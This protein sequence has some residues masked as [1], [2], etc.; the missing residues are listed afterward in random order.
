MT[1]SAASLLVLALLTPWSAPSW[2]GSGEGAV[3]DDL[4]VHHAEDPDAPVVTEANLLASERFWPYQVE[5]VRPWQVPGG[6]QAIQPGVP[7]VLIRVESGGLARVDFGRDGL[8]E[9]PVAETDLLDRANQ[10]RR[11]E[12]YK[13]APNLVLALGPRLLDSESAPP[14]P[15]GMNR[16][17]KPVGFLCVFAD[18]G[19]A[20]FADLVG[21]L[22][23][24]RGRHGVASVLLPQGEHA[25]SELGEQ[26]RTLGWT[27]P[28]VYDGLSELYTRSL[29]PEGSRPPA[30]LLATS[31]GRVLFQGTWRSDLVPEL[32][33]ALEKGFGGASDRAGVSPGTASERR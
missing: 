28:F 3:V 27:V 8:H 14:H 1:R 29:L 15:I 24:L 13:M 22:G 19:A 20:A 33:A 32:S 23:P 26:L 9:V 30:L 18:P 11:G 12:L 2:A 4:P 31:E 21:A 16:A 6:G 7:A 17:S 5:L 25:D 10:I